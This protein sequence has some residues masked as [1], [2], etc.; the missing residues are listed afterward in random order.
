MSFRKWTIWRYTLPLRRPLTV[1]HHETTTRKGL[2]LQLIGD[3][4]AIGLGEAAPL[5]GLHNETLED[6]AAQLQAWCE[7]NQAKPPSQNDTATN[8]P[9]TVAFAISTALSQ[10]GAGATAPASVAVYSAGLVNGSIDECLD[11]AIAQA[12]AGARAIK[13]KVGRRPLE[14]D[15]QLI[16]TLRSTLDADVEIRV[17]AN[18]AWRLGEAESF[19]E[20]RDCISF[21][22]EPLQ[23]PTGLP[24]LCQKTG[25]SVALDESVLD[26]PDLKETVGVNAVVLKPTLL[27]NIDST[28][29][30]MEWAQQNGKRAIISATFESDVGQR[31]I[32]RIAAQLPNEVHGLGTWAW[33]ETPLVGP[34][35]RFEN[36]M[37]AYEAAQ[38]LDTRSLSLVRIAG[39]M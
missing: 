23:D 20:V 3:N 32:A 14:Q 21:V 39:N 28:I 5:P 38:T 34:G 8:R 17:D 13:V 36:G 26:Q 7:S 31:A 2:I 24:A 15:K 12:K 18:R 33:F 22:E 27:G 29:A 35:P 37:L 6:A 19:A 10:I 1:Q 16:R 4:G 9:S 30:W 11:Q 25:I